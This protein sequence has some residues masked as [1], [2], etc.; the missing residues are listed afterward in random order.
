MNGRVIDMKYG[1]DEAKLIAF[2]RSDTDNQLFYQ[3]RDGVIHS[4]MNDYCIESRRMN[5]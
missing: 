3:D 4:K 1:D 2:E 5:F